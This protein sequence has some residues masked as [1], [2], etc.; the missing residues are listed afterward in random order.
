MAYGYLMGFMYDVGNGVGEFLRDE[1]KA[2]YTPM[3]L[4]EI[5]TEYIDE[6]NLLCVFL[7]RRNIRSYIKKHTTA[8]GVEYAE[9]FNQELRFPEDYFEGDLQ[10][11][12][13]NI[14]SLLDA[15]C[16]SRIKKMFS[17]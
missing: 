12:L 2:G 16:K 11:F 10:V 6:R 1:E 3:T 17:Y 5:V 7:L 14:L 15:E 9:P 4:P 8:N 13:Q